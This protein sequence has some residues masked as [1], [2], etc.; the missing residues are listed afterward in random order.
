MIQDTNK[1]EFKC[2][3]TKWLSLPSYRPSLRLSASTVPHIGL[4][5][6]G[7]NMIRSILSTVLAASLRLKRKLKSSYLFIFYFLFIILSQFEYCIIFCI[8]S[9]V[10]SLFP[11][12][13]TASRL[14]WN[15]NIKK[16]KA[17]CFSHNT[18]HYLHEASHIELVLKHLLC[19]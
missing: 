5:I 7:P 6:F 13:I 12:I 8:V 2:D 4:M 10:F 11:T 16:N 9:V 14:K 3:R 1:I 15:L 18:H 19:P 17:N